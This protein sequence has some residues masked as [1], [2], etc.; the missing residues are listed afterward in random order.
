MKEFIKKHLDLSKG[1]NI[2]YL[3]AISAF[4]PYYIT[5]IVMA[6][7]GFYIL[8]K[9]NIKKTV[10]SHFGSSLI[11]IFSI[12]TL[13]TAL[14]FKNWLGA[15]CS[16]VFF[17]IMVIGYYVRTVM[18]KEVFEK[19][20]D[21]CCVAS[22]GTS[23]IVFIEQGLYL[24]HQHLFPIYPNIKE[25]R[26]FGNLFGN[27]YFSFY[28]HPNYLGSILAAVILICAYK[29]VVKRQNKIQYYVV[30]VFAAVAMF[31]TESMFAWVVVF[32]GLS[33]LL[34]LARRHLLLSILFIVAA[35]GF[36]ILLNVPELFPRILHIGGTTDNRVQIW[37][38]AVNSLSESPWFGRGFF[39]YYQVSLATEGSYVTTHAHNIFI[40]PLLSFGIIGSIILFICVFILFE[41]I[42]LCKN[43]LRKSGI[44]YLIFALTAGILIHSIIDMTMLWMQTALLYCVIFGGIG[45]DERTFYSIFKRRRRHLRNKLNTFT[46]D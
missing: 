34:I 32:M 3:T 26:C 42:V 15:L 27:M 16:V 44:T 18:T 29:V 20:L 46:E 35:S 7:L 1:R 17:L 23:I 12:L 37:D 25:F 41:K 10:F 14:Y 31:L 40:E 9:T 30:A 36:F 33:V 19:A 6:V 38:L 21:I 45:A 39:G 11:P 2:V 28:F 43:F 22:I 13:V 24:C 4:L 8:F 5:C